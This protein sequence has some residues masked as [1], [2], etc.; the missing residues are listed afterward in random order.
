MM[1]K[2]EMFFFQEISWTRGP[3][4]ESLTTV[5]G[6]LPPHFLSN[7]TVKVIYKFVFRYTSLYKFIQVDIQVCIS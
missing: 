7:D 5:T 6:S 1:K 4:V 3:H 2:E